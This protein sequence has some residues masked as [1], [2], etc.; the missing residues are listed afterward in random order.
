MV[1]QSNRLDTELSL[2]IRLIASPISWAI[3]RSRIFSVTRTPSVARMLSVT[4]SC[5]SELAATRATA[6]AESTPWVT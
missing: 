2:E 6:P 4:T 5:S 1:G 3:D